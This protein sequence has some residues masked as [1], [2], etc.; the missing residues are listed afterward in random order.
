MGHL[1]RHRRRSE[2][3]PTLVETEVILLSIFFI[4]QMY[5]F[6]ML[7]NQTKNRQEYQGLKSPVDRTI[8]D[9]DAGSKYHIPA[10]V[11]YI[12]HTK[13]P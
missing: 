13:L 9:F 10:N 4:R 11:E 2:I 12:R 1:R 8:E 7:I 5:S 6:L 3:Q